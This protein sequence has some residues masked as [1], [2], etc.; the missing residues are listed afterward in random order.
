MLKHNPKRIWNF[1]IWNFGIWN[2]GIWNFGIWNFR[3]WKFGIHK[4]GIWKFRI[5]NWK[6]K[7]LFS[8][9]GPVRK[10][11][12]DIPMFW[13]Y[14]PNFVLNLATFWA[15]FELFWAFRCY[16]LGPLGLFIW[17]FGAY[18]VVEVRSKNIFGTYLCRQSTLVLESQPHLFIFYL[19]LAT[20][21]ASF[22]LFWAIWGYFLVLWDYF[23][24][25]GQVQKHFWNLLM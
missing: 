11:F 25:R 3:I 7:G 18:C 23:W 14:S 22:A 19:N 13:M 15:S 1:R 6:V 4:F 2:F 12:W 9:W 20:F 16:F 10:L 8:G 5:E 17:S 21:W 24:S